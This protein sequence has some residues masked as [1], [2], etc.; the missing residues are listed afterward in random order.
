[1][2]TIVVNSKCIAADRQLLIKG[3]DGGTHFA[4]GPKLKLSDCGTFVY[5]STGIDLS[6]NHT[7]ELEKLFRMVAHHFAGGGQLTDAGFTELAL[8]VSK[9]VR[10]PT[11]ILTRKLFISIIE[12]LI[13]ISDE[14]IDYFAVGTGATFASSAMLSGRTPKQAVE[15]ANRMDTLSG[16]GVDVYHANKLKAIKVG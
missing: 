7:D 2:T 12:G 14:Y 13:S 9:R 10:K 1:M 8:A 5:G 6:K 3:D 4:D 16:R 11:L 15:F